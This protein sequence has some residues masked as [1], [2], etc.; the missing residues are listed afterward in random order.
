MLK[1]DDAASLQVCR[2][3]SE[4]FEAIGTQQIITEDTGG[5]YEAK[6]EESKAEKQLGRV[7]FRDVD[8]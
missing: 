3:I 5:K 8:E 6:N 2:A 1:W 7:S 4:T